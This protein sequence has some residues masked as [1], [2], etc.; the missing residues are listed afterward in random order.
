MTK[1]F[2]SVGSFVKFGFGICGDM[3]AQNCGLEPGALGGCG[4]LGGASRMGKAAAAVQRLCVWWEES[5]AAAWSSEK[6][7]A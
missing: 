6:S 5:R 1:V 2:R 7:S 4:G 3:V